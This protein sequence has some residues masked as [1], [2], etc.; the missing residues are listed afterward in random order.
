MTLRTNTFNTKNMSFGKKINCKFWNQNLFLIPF[1]KTRFNP[2]NTFF[3]TGPMPFLG[4]ER[5]S[6]KQ[7]FW[8]SLFEKFGKGD[9]LFWKMFRRNFSFILNFKNFGNE[10]GTACAIPFP[11]K[12]FYPHFSQIEFVKKGERDQPLFSL[13]TRLVQKHLESKT[14]FKNSWRSPHS[15]NQNSG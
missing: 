10:E 5:A 6:K 11:K 9:G 7:V 2:K 8:N 14:L 1:P 4:T 3:G 15:Q 12:V 13:K